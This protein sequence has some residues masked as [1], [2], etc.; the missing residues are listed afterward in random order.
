VEDGD[1]LL[2]QGLHAEVGEPE[3]EVELICHGLIV[4]AG[5]EEG[6]FSTDGTE[7]AG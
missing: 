4:L 3:A 6:Q 7:S 5:E 1:E 2:R